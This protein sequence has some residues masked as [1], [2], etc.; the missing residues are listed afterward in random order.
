MKQNWWNAYQI[1]KLYGDFIKWYYNFET[2]HC[3]LF[4]CIKHFFLGVTNSQ[5]PLQC[6]I[7]SDITFDTA[8]AV[9]EPDLRITPD[10]PYLARTRELWGV[11]CEDFG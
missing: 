10:N 7:Y 2:L 6:V 3:Q 8:I 4:Q 5:V 11:Y 9:T 1:P